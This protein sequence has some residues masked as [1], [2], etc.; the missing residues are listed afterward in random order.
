MRVFSPQKS[1]A[2]INSSLTRDELLRR[3]RI[4]VID[5]ERPEI[6]DDL[7]R[8]HFAVDYEPDIDATKIDLIDKRI[9]DLILLDFGNVG[10][11]FGSDEGLSL[12]RHIKRV[13]P[14]VVVISYTS[15]ALGASQADFYRLCDAVL[16]KD[17][18][19]S[20]SLEKIELELRRAHSIT[21]VWSGLLTVCGVPAGSA[22]DKRLQNLLVRGLNRPPKLE[23]L[24]QSVMKMLTSEEMQKTGAILLAKVIE[25]A[26][27]SVTGLPNG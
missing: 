2:S 11:A 25:L 24:K 8:A 23:A 3:S 20:E 21:N 17:A 12:L 14:A 5:D 4:L 16:P 27:R 15:K 22:D 26:V 6:V 13:N 18:G 19:I 7:K 9:Y 10:R 1:I